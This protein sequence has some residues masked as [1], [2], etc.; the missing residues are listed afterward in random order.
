M[1]EKKEMKTPEIDVTELEEKDLEQTAGGNIAPL[2]PAE[3][4]VVQCGCN[5]VSGCSC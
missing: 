3:N 5:V 1:S 4:N 2:L